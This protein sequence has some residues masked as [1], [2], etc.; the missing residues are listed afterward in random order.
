MSVKTLSMGSGKIFRGSC[1][2]HL[3]DVVF[4]VVKVV[5]L[6]VPIHLKEVEAALF[7]VKLLLRSRNDGQGQQHLVLEDRV[8]LSCVLGK[9]RVSDSRLLS[10]TRKWICISIAGDLL[11]VY[12]WIP[13]VFNVADSD[14]RRWENDDETRGS[15]I[16]RNSDFD[17]KCALRVI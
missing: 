4:I 3:S 15:Q 1:L 7:V 9:G 5:D 13:L 17:G 10:L 16:V 14:S 6:S 11:L 8:T 2:Q 12:R